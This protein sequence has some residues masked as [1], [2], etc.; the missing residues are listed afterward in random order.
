MRAKGWKPSENDLDWCREMVR[1][2]T[3][4]GVWMCPRYGHVYRFNHNEKQITL[5]DGDASHPI[6]QRNIIAFGRVGYTVTVSPV[7]EPRAL[8]ESIAKGGPGFV[9]L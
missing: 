1:V 5:V 9:L 8:I 6:H 7:R 3:H 4:D 2:M